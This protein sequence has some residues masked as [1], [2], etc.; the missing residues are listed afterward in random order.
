MESKEDTSLG[1]KCMIYGMWKSSFLLKGLQGMLYQ[2]GKLFHWRNMWR[3]NSEMSLRIYGI[4]W[5]DNPEN[6]VGEEAGERRL[7]SSNGELDRWEWELRNE[8]VSREVVYSHA[9]KQVRMTWHLVDF[10]LLVSV[11][12]GGHFKAY[13]KRVLAWTI[14]PMGII[15][16]NLSNGE[17][18]LNMVKITFVLDISLYHPP[19]KYSDFYSYWIVETILEF[20]GQCEFRF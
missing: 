14:G 11:D 15:I 20:P 8:W 9:D 4:W 12:A 7:I 16:F 10:I 13:S 17:K 5:A 1:L 3:E 18:Y 19:S 2:R 6:K